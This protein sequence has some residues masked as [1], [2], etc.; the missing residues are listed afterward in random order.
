LEIELADD[1][2]VYQEYRS[3]I[4]EYF[5]EEIY[6]SVKRGS[7]SQ[8]PNDIENNLLMS[9]PSEAW[10]SIDTVPEGIARGIALME[11]LRGLEVSSPETENAIWEAYSSNSENVG[12]AVDDASVNLTSAEINVLSNI[13]EDAQCLM[14]DNLLEQAA[15]MQ[16]FDGPGSWRSRWLIIG[17]SFV[18]LTPKTETQIHEASAELSLIAKEIR[19]L[20]PG[21]QAKFQNYINA[22][23]R[24]FSHSSLKKGVI[25][26]KAQ[27]ER[28]DESQKLMT[29]G[30]Q[31]LMWY[32][33]SYGNL[34]NL[35]QEFASAKGEIVA[36]LFEMSVKYRN[37]SML[38]KMVKNVATQIPNLDEQVN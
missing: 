12:T 28:I 2:N 6:S 35:S 9:L 21:F 22:S 29:T 36:T 1:I 15:I 7:N 37:A 38:L 24:M 34:H 16:R 25:G 4:R 10:E 18:I 17:D 8:T 13:L 5:T 33:Q 27:N 3:R 20:L 11:V 23:M 14:Q 32:A 26:M 31:Q 30:A 19:A